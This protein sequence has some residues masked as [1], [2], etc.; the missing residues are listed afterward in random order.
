MSCTSHGR[1]H[2][3]VTQAVWAEGAAKG[4]PRGLTSSFL[5]WVSTVCTPPAASQQGAALVQ[6]HVFLTG[7]NSTG[8]RGRGKRKKEKIKKDDQLP[9]LNGMIEGYIPAG[10]ISNT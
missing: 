6:A 3:E 8:G 7:C 5:L 9:A 4:G 1:A 2:E 10:K